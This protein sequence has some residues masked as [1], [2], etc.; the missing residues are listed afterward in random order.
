M[1]RPEIDWR[2]IARAQRNG[3]AVAVLCLVVW[4]LSLVM[5]HS[6]EMALNGAQDEFG[7]LVEERRTLAARIEAAG[8]HRAH[9]AQLV[10]QGRV[11]A[12]ERLMIIQGLRDGAAALGLPWLRYHAAPERD[13]AMPYL[14]PVEMAPVR[15]SRVEIEAGVI[16]EGDLLRL[17]ARLGDTQ[18]LFHVSGCALERLAGDTPVAAGRANVAARCAL[19]WLHIATSPRD[20]GET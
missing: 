4:G 9:W 8:L 5:R 19:D 15:A 16:H 14:D 18:A 2:H 12:G 1:S 7:T 10:A 6:G 11:G 13:Y 3:L 17:L 20:G